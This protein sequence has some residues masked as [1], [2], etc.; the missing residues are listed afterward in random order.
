MKQITRLT[1]V[2][3]GLALAIPTAAQSVMPIPGLRAELRPVSHHVPVGQPVWVRFS[4]ENTTPEPITLRVPGTEPEI[5]SPHAGLPLSHVFSGRDASG[6]AVT[7]DS[8]RHWN[9]PVGFRAP[10]KAPILMISA[11]GSVGLT[12]DLRDFFPSLRGAGGFRVSWKPYGGRVS[13]DTAVITIAALKRAEI[14][15]DDG[16]MTLRFMYIDAPLHVTNFIELAKSGF[17]NGKTFHRL[18]PGYLLQGGCPRGDGTGIRIDGKR[19]RSEFNGNPM[20]K[21]TVA[22]ALLED[23][24][25][26]AS[27][28]F[29]ICNTR[30]KEWDGRYT[31]FAE[32]IGEESFLTLDRL[33][34][35]AVDDQ[36]RPTRPLSMRN[37]RIID[38]PPD[39]L[40]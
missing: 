22:M 4:I 12:I 6:V 7:T 8:G 5:P 17:Y 35:T 40:P 11:F 36:S 38:A 39:E 16:T 32:L 19:L 18:E 29:F 1:A 24:V 37:V 2:L 21:G 15:T 26:S 30:Q 31:V 20:R 9:R 25:D 28:Q 13:G 3:F 10:T 27:C 14:Q 33:M 23:D 34:A